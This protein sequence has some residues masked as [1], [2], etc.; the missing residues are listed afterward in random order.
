MLGPVEE[1]VRIARAIPGSHVQALKT[2][3]AQSLG[4]AVLSVP[5]GQ[6]KLGSRIGEGG[7]RP[8]NPRLTGAGHQDLL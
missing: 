8:T 3:P 4:Q 5:H 2:N 6:A 7:P 1:R